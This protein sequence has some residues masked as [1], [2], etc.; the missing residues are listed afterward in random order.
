[1][2]KILIA[3][4]LQLYS[5]VSFAQIVKFNPGV[6][7]T[8]TVTVE[9]YADVYFGFD[10]N[11]PEN[12]NRPY[13]VSQHRHNEFNINLAYISLKYNAS[14]V[15][16][17]FTPGFGTYMN[18][19][20]AAERI[21]LKNIVE[22]YV[23]VKLFEHHD[24]WLDAGVFVAPYTTESAISLDQLL[25]TRTF[26]AEYSPYYLTGAKLSIPISKKVNLYLYL[27]N[28]WQVI[29]DVNNPLAFGSSV[30]YKPTEK[31]SVVWNTYL[32][33]EY[34]VTTPTYRGRQFSDLY[35]IYNPTKKLNLSL[36]VYA[37]RQKTNDSITGKS[38]VNWGQANLNARYNLNAENSI[39]A[40]A[41]YFNDRHNVFITPVTGQ[42]DFECY[43]YSLGYNR[44]ITNN[45]MFRIESR[46]F[47][48]PGNVF[49][50]RD[51][52]PTDNS[53][54]IIGGLTAKF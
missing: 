43:S 45:V 53:L 50:D 17:T 40:R 14:R 52:N 25:Y 15:R 37:G 42:D 22:A 20:Y 51:L 11:H 24:I 41:E 26:G 31:L 23:G 21:T 32:G 48:S 3:T 10:S 2:K 16:A 1:M 19:N 18:S 5:V 4:F 33:S 13:S 44:T 8:K 7:S 34:S 46:Y 6:D 47:Q 9:G 30:E 39:S 28:G 36:D 38:A 27:A 49:L 29:E 12:A 35:F 54:L